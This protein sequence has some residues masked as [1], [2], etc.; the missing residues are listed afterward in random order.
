MKKIMRQLERKQH[1]ENFVGLIQQVHTHLSSEAYDFIEH[2]YI[3][4]YEASWWVTFYSRASYYRIKHKA[5]DEFM[6][7]ILVF[8]SEEEILALLDS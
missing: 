2:E 8:W 7:C 3:N 6:E 4:Y 1:L 5:L